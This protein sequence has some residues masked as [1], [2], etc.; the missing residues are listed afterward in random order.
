MRCDFCL[1]VR[2]NDELTANGRSGRTSMDVQMSGRR[3][4]NRATSEGDQKL[5]PVILKF[6]FKPDKNCLLGFWILNTTKE[7]SRPC[8]TTQLFL[9]LVD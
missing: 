3:S 6:E 1:A 7:D 5:F 9:T 4:S 2:E 8:T